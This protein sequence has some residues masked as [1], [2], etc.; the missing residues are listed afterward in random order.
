MTGS[1]KV[2]RIIKYVVLLVLIPAVIVAGGMIFRNKFY[3]YVSL[4]VAVLATVPFF[5]TF[6]RK[7]QNT[8]KLILIAVLTALS[9]I[10][11][12]IFAAIPGFKPVTAMVVI[13]AIYF[14]AE[15]GFLTGALTAV[16]SNLYFGQGPWTPF[17][18]FTWGLI[19]LIAGLMAKR[20]L[21]SRWALSLFGIFA[22]VFYSAVMDVWT[23]LWWGDGFNWKRYLAALITAL[24]FTA[25]YA[26][27]NVIF[28]WLLTKPIG[29]KLERVKV[30]YGIS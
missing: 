17:Q 9:V 7:E 13:T 20:L 11:R 18:M 21:N 16:I 19:G 25:I 22:G 12:L 3:A 15:A 6:E 10:G 30:K 1:S 4:I 24:P 23:V 29:E 27:S 26:V 2:K 8:V 14:G 5:M 28:L